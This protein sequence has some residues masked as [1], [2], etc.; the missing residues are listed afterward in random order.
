MFGDHQPYVEDEFYKTLLSQKYEDI[1]SKEAT[2]NKYITPF[3]IWANYDIEEK[4]IDKLSS[5]YL[6]AYMLDVAGVKQTEY[7]KYLL[8]LSETLP[9]IDTVGYIDAENNY[10]KWSDNSPYKQTISEYEKI[11]YN[12]I[13]DPENKKNEIF[14]LDG[15]VMPETLET[16]ESEE[17]AETEEPRE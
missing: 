14:F 9:V 2:E 4:Q 11:Q 15:Y 17:S 5:N 10:Y 7:N 12:N 13:F 6:S 8:K 16:E 3:M 1:N